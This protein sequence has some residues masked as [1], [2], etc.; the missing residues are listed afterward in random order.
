MKKILLIVLIVIVGLYIIVCLAFYF[1]QEKI[2]FFPETLEKNYQFGFEQ[3]FEERNFE[4][5]DGKLINGLLFRADSTK[6][7]IFYLHGNAGSLKGWGNVA[8][9]YTELNYDIFIL[10]YRGYGKSEGKITSQKQLYDDNQMVYNKLKEEYNEQ[11][12][13]VLGYSIGSGMAANLASVN[14]PKRLILQAPY[15]SLTDLAGQM[16]PFL[17]SFTLRYKFATNMY[18]KNCNMPVTIFHGNQDAVIPYESSLRLKE[19][20]KS[21]IHLITLDG[22]G[23]N[24]MSKNEDYKNEL[25]TILSK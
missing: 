18:L 24:G 6:G 14:N 16:F 2:I 4:T 19:E 3:K 9:T 1:F 5:A 8:G 25:K 12:I 23:H 11:D 13:I 15:Y 20:F 7:L 21:T 10:D 17:P 22:M